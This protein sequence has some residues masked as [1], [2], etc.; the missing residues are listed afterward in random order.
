MANRPERWARCH[1]VQKASGS[2]KERTPDAPAPPFNPVSAQTTVTLSTATVAVAT[3]SPLSRRAW[4]GGKAVDLGSSLS[5]AGDF[6][7]PSLG[8]FI[9]RMRGLTVTS[10]QSSPENRTVDSHRAREDRTG[11]RDSSVTTTTLEAAREAEPQP[12]RGGC[13]WNGDLGVLKEGFQEQQRGI[14]WAC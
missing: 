8:F 3:G 14:C 12:S 7:S 5:S 2:S 1:V 11:S 9:Y 13:V 4:C 6:T 10:A